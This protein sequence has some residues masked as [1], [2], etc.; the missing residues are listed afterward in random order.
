MKSKYDL[1]FVG[2]GPSTLFGVLEL[3]NKGYNKDI[4]IIEKGKPIENRESTDVVNGVG[5]SGLFSDS[6]LS[7]ALDVGGIIPGLTQTQLNK[8]ENI[9]LKSINKFKKLTPDK[10]ALDWDVT[11]DFDAS[12]TSLSWN[13]HKTCHVGT[14]NGHKIYYEMEKFIESQPNI[15]VETETEVNDIIYKNRLYFIYTNNGALISE[16]I[17]LATGQK[18]T[19]PS[20][21]IK[22]FNLPSSFRAFQLGIRVVDEMNPQYED[23]IKANYDFKFVKNYDYGKVKVRVR[24]FCCNSGNAQVCAEITNEGFVCFNGHAYKNPNPDNNSVNYGIMCEIE[25]LDEYY[26]KES[27]IDLMRKINHMDTW[28]ADNFY[29]D[30]KLEEDLVSPKRKLL[31]GFDFLKGY[32]PEEAILSLTDFVSELNKIVD[33]SKATFLYPEVKLSGEIPNIDYTT[34]ETKLKGLYMIGDCAISRGIVKSSLTGIMLADNLM[35]EEN[36]IRNI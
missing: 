35:E 1:V 6:K 18:N 9:I 27:Q 26:T 7:S 13:R 2:F 29:N 22:Q 14:D 15:D 25:G 3:I 34:Y 5:G 12:K 24:T 28:Y 30:D 31:N 10:S 19:L 33:L 20:K 16:K 17:V 8:Y 4:L 23:I 32:Y 21:I 11:Q 36:A